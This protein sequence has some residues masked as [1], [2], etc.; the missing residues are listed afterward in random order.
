MQID[1]S[2]PKFFH[3]TSYSSY[4]SNSFT[5]NVFYYTVISKKYI[6]TDKISPTQSI[7]LINA[8][9]RSFTPLGISPTTA[10]LGQF[11]ANHT[12]LVV[13]NL[14]VPVILGCDFMSK[15]ALVLDIQGGTV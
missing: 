10:T 9:D 7:Q 14:I 11:S 5:A 15:H 1:F 2:L 3:Q 12:F 4:L 8:D 13:D 6:I